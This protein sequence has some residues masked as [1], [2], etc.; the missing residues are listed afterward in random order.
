MAEWA[1]KR[2]WKDAIVVAEGADWA[3]ELDGRRLNTP[4]RSPML[5]PTRALAVDVASEWAAQGEAV[6]PG[7]MPYTRSANSA[8]DTVRPGRDAIARQLSEYAETDLTCYRATAPAELVARQRTAWDPLLDWAAERAGVRLR[9]TA[10]VMPV[11]Q[12]DQAN[13]AYFQIVNTFS[14]FELAGLYELIVLSGSIVI[15]LATAQNHI[16]PEHGWDA[17]RIDETW[18]AEQ[19]GRDSEAEAEADLK[20]AAFLHAAGFLQKSRR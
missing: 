9:V 6:D 3:V 8:I 12:Q 13:P 15:G 14:D 20:R 5:L 1:A 11:Q 4:G 18:Q 19:W 16:S 10:G 2:F 7:S 17:S